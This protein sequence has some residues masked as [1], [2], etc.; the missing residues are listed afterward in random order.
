MN[1]G[2]D[3][4]AE[5][6]GRKDAEGKFADA[7]EETSSGGWWAVTGFLVTANPPQG[8]VVTM[9]EGEAASSGNGAPDYEDIVALHNL[10][11]EGGA[12]VEL[13]GAEK[14]STGAIGGPCHLPGSG[15]TLTVS[16]LPLTTP[17]SP[18][19]SRHPHLLSLSLSRSRS[20]SSSAS[21]PPFP[22]LSRPPL[23]PPS[24]HSLPLAMSFLCLPLLSS[25]SPFYL[26]SPSSPSTS[27]SPSPSPNH[28]L[29][30]SRHLLVSSPFRLPALSFASIPSLLPFPHSLPHP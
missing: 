21:N 26:P 6:A 14:K 1:T 15:V 2:T 29:S 3:G 19:P 7:I 4:K 20:L 28:T 30:S 17:H 8:I 27:R 5:E 16:A 11:R 23:L 9:I 10:G 22:S 12:P 13:A 24:P 25:A 18:S